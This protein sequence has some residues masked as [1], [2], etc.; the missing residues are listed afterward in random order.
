MLFNIARAVGRNTDI[1]VFDCRSKWLKDKPGGRSCS[2]SVSSSS[3]ESTRGADDGKTISEG[4]SGFGGSGRGV[5]VFS[6]G[7]MMARS[8][9]VG[10]S[11]RLGGRLRCIGGLDC[12]LEDGADDFANTNGT[13]VCTVSKGGGPGNAGGG[14][15][16]SGDEG[17][18]GISGMYVRDGGGGIDGVQGSGIGN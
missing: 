11:D 3:F 17:G 7:V 6:F 5:T 1:S 14:G 16:L 18:P 9:D 15:I 10:L 13:E 2:S 12:R 4:G 8:D